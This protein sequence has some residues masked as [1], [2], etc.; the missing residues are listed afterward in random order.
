MSLLR[1]GQQAGLHHLQSPHPSSSPAPGPRLLHAEG[2]LLLQAGRPGE[3][4]PI[5]GSKT[6]SGS[7]PPGAFHTGG[8][9]TPQLPSCPLTALFP[10]QL[11]AV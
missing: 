10:S 3:C 2:C 1:V 11:P 9:L 6:G 8:F 5:G 4:A 7:P